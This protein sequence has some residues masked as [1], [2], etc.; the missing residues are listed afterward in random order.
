MRVGRC[1]IEYVTT[2]ISLV[3]W[4]TRPKDTVHTLTQKIVSQ[5]VL[6]LVILAMSYFLG[7][8]LPDL[9]DLI[10]PVL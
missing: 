2:I 5:I 10:Y 1:R 4:H 3:R 8:I 7:K 6:G 9:V